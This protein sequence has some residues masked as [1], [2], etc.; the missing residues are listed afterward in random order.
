MNVLH[1]LTTVIQIQP[2]KTLMDPSCVLATMDTLGMELFAKVNRYL[3]VL[4]INCTR[5]LKYN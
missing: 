4:G 5:S 3:L 2:A 1:L